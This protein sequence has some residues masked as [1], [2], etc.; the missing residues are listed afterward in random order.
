LH[1]GKKKG[2][3]PSPKRFSGRLRWVN[4][5]KKT[6]QSPR[7]EKSPSMWKGGG[8]GRLPR[9][10]SQKPKGRRWPPGSKKG[11][12]RS[13]RKGQKGELTMDFG[14]QRRKKFVC[15]K[16]GAG[17]KE[18]GLGKKKKGEGSL[19]NH[20]EGGKNKGGRSSE[21]GGARL[22]EK[23]LQVRPPR[24]FGRGGAVDANSIF[25]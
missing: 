25:R 12:T 21:R 3:R 6:E 11:K 10:G 1:E 8:G 13:P 15:Q 5:K 20:R 23:T 18:N 24:G 2:P 19:K 4:P 7:G 9:W 17:G 14:P 16:K 22:K